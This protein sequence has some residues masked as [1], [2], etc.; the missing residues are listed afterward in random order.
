M[1]HI[2]FV[3]LWVLTQSREFEKTFS[4]TALKSTR[5]WMFLDKMVLGEGKT[6]I[7]M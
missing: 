6:L 4:F 5:G 1:K 7:K 2:L 3:L